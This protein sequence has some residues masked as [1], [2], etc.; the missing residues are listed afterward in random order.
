MS[1]YCSFPPP[2]HGNCHT[3]KFVS[4]YLLLN[5]NKIYILFKK[6]CGGKRRIQR[7]KGLGFQLG[8]WPGCRSTHGLYTD[9]SDSTMA[10]LSF[11]FL[12]STLLMSVP[13]LLCNEVTQGLGTSHGTKCQP[14]PPTATGRLTALTSQHPGLTRP[15][16][17]QQPWQESNSDQTPYVRPELRG[18]WV[19]TDFPFYS[20]TPILREISVSKNKMLLECCLLGL[21]WN[22]LLL[23]NLEKQVWKMHLFSPWG[24]F[25]C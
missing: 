1:S 3:V 24:L 23:L 2:Q 4:H 22:F 11:F 13:N 17:L 5:A 12:L 25:R 6:Q 15:E 18:K 9:F 21:A 14:P 8:I 20:Q 16:L 10:P 19:R 7:V